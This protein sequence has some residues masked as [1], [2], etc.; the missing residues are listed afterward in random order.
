MA[1]DPS[2]SRPAPGRDIELRTDEQSPGIRMTAPTAGIPTALMLPNNTAAFELAVRLFANGR[3]PYTA[4]AVLRNSQATR[5]RRAVDYLLS[6]KPDLS[7]DDILPLNIL[8]TA[9][10]VA[11]QTIRNNQANIIEHANAIETCVVRYSLDELA[12]FDQRLLDLPPL[13]AFRF[14]LPANGTTSLISAVFLGNGRDHAGLNGWKTRTLLA[15]QAVG[16]LHDDAFAASQLV[17]QVAAD[18]TKRQFKD[19]LRSRCQAAIREWDNSIRQS[20]ASQALLELS[21][22]IYDEP[23]HDD[24]SF[25]DPTGSSPTSAANAP[26]EALHRLL[27]GPPPPVTSVSTLPVDIAAD[28]IVEQLLLHLWR[29]I[30]LN[31]NEQCGQQ[32]QVLYL[33]DN[34]WYFCTRSNSHA[35]PT[36]PNTNLFETILLSICTG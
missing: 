21:E 17:P 19:C 31:Q 22:D 20:Q 8:P 1:S 30:D 13:S 6:I 7:D 27:L 10:A 12:D 36:Y 16:L 29:V 23:L 2:S 18:A 35:I 26:P 4:N 5:L 15:A 25:S 34:Q 32:V 9:D 33:G 3:A 28:P 24:M 11:N 14:V